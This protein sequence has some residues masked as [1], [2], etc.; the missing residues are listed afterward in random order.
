M[1]NNQIM[2][3]DVKDFS[4][5]L[6]LPVMSNNVMGRACYCVREAYL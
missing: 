5:F 2:R 4:F 1:T 3:E 6:I